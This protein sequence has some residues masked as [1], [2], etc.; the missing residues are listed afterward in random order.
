MLRLLILVFFVPLFPTLANPYL[1][2]MKRTPLVEMRQNPDFQSYQIGEGTYGTPSI[3]NYGGIYTLRIGKYCSIATGVTFLLNESHATNWVT[4]Y[5]F[6]ALWPEGKGFNSPPQR[7]HTVV[8][9][10]V[11]IGYN[12]LILSGVA[13]GD[14]AIIGAGSVVVKDVPPY[15][16]VG[17]VPAKPIR[18]RVPEELIPKLLQIAWWNWPEEKIAAAIPYLLSDDINRFIDFAESTQ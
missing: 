13:I 14:G 15:T 9:N 12:A 8:G 7:G 6:Y 17:G 16:I 10:D 2:E 1:P 11:H 5:P 4:T 3:I 18:K